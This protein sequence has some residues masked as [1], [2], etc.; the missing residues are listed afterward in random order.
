MEQLFVLFDSI[1]VL[2]PELRAYIKSILVSRSVKKKEILL[3]EGQVAR[4]I[5]FIEKGLVR[6]YRFKKGKERTSWF[7]KEND[8]CVSILSFFL[9]TPAR[10][11]IEALEDCVIYYIT[12]E[13]L[14]K[15]YELFPEFNLHGRV[16]LELYYQLSEKRNEMREMSTLG[17]FEF[18]M[19]RQP[20]LM[21]RVS[22]KL[23]ASYLNM[24]PETFSH[25]KS[26]FT[27]KKGKNGSDQGI[28]P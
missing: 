19:E 14:Q 15:A 23:L 26:I 2:S 11:T 3:K 8:V 21:G 6:S 9:Q 17:R 27:H 1:K 22:Q 18:L 16:I 13:E 12:Y 10:E 7:M 25:Q 28:E 4:H 20:E 24:E 5:Y